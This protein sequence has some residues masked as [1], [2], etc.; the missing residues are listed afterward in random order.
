MPSQKLAFTP[1]EDPRIELT[2]GGYMSDFTVKLDDQTI[3]EIPGGSRALKKGDT[4]ILPDGSELSIKLRQSMMI[5][6]LQV[7]HNGNPLP[8]SASH[9]RRKLTAAVRTAFYWGLAC[10]IFGLL[11]ATIRDP[12][13]FILGFEPYSALFGF[14]LMVLSVVIAR[15]SLIGA[16]LATILYIVDLI[17]HIM[18]VRDFGVGILFLSP[19]IILFRIFGAVI[20]AQGIGAISLLRS[21]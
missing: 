2:W 5:D 15:W 6:E 9:P 4:F 7:L 1:D 20:L 19:L 8:G 3:G 21:Q 16:G 17:L 18:A 12:R 10:I 13:I 14:A 11:Q